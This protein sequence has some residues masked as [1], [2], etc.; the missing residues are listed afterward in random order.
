MHG[1]TGLKLPYSF[2]LSQHPFSGQFTP[3]MVMQ[4]DFR[5]KCR[6]FKKTFV[7]GNLILKSV[8]DSSLLMGKWMTLMQQTNNSFSKIYKKICGYNVFMS[9]Q[10]LL[11]LLPSH[12]G[13]SAKILEAKNF[14]VYHRVIGIK[15]MVFF[16]L[17]RA[18][19]RMWLL[20]ITFNSMLLFF[21]FSGN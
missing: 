8:G 4:S 12:L 6:T 13:L 17:S 3:L 5:N 11:K 1:S 2:P 15:K 18:A 9:I 10:L 21:L 14:I 19:H 20:S 16:S 7:Q